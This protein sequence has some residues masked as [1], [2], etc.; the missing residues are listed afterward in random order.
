MLV[1]DIGANHGEFSKH[2]LGLGKDI[3]VIAIEPNPNCEKQLNVLVRDYPNHFR[4]I[5]AAFLTRDMYAEFVPIYGADLFG[6]Q[7]ASV[8]PINEGYQ[9]NQFLEREIQRGGTSPIL[10]KGFRVQDL[11]KVVGDQVIDFVKI[12][13]QGLD[14]FL[15]DELLNFFEC[16]AGAVEIEVSADSNTNLYVKGEGGISELLKVSSI[17][18]KADLDVVRINPAE[19]TCREYNLFFARIGHTI[20]PITYF[21]LAACGIFSRFWKIDRKRDQKKTLFA[22]DL[23]AISKKVMIRLYKLIWKF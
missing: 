17:L 23:V 19:A 3:Q 13:T 8:F 11:R 2:I 16:N 12:D 18:Q 4:W 1:L 20:D 10:T 7:V 22:S 5:N 6:G 21:D 14:L 15:L 9:G